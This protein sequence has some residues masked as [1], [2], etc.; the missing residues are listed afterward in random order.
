LPL[1]PQRNYLVAC[2]L[3]YVL[4]YL[5][6]FQFSDEAILYLRSL[7]LFSDAFLESLRRFRFRGDVYAIPE[8][9]V[10]F[11]NEPLIELIAPLPQAQ[12]VEFLMNQIQLHVRRRIWSCGR[13]GSVVDLEPPNA[14][15]DSALKPASVYRDC[16][17]SNVL[18]GQTGA[19]RL[20][21]PWR[22]YILSFENDWKPFGTSYGRPEHASHR[23]LRRRQ[24]RATYHSIGS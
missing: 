13:Q 21:E 1:P 2:G 14:R 8:G 12:L 4:H 10:V 24:S 23:Y 5:E 18:A 19:S 20:R 7:K 16:R 11:A 22:G 3:E 6:S 17:T 9:T 15:P